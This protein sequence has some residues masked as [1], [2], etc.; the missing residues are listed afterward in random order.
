MQAYI[1]EIGD[2]HLRR[3]PADLDRK[4][5]RDEHDKLLLERTCVKF[6]TPTPIK[7]ALA[8]KLTSAEKH[9]LLPPFF[10]SNV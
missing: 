10:K 2:E 9:M 5:Y 1:K 7:A 3:V 8:V 6:K 4:P